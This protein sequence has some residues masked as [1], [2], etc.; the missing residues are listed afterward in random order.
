[1]SINSIRRVTLPPLQGHYDVPRKIDGLIRTI[2]RAPEGQRNALTYWAAC[3]FAEL[4]NLGEITHRDAFAIVI[5]AAT[6]NGHTR[7]KAE[8]VARNAFAKVGAN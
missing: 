7:A 4:V 6:R 1:L 5:E 8:N 3:R 2:A